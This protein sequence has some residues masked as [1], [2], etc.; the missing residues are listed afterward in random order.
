[1]A[2]KAI[3]SS[4]SSA[5]TSGSDVIEDKGKSDV[6]SHNMTEAMGAHNLTLK[7]VDKLRKI[8]VKTIFFLQQDPDLEYP[9]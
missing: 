7:D 9:K 4:A 5:D 8:G 2:I 6:Y 1:M 3:S